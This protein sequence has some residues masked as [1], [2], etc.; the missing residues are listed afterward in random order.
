[1]GPL[2][3]TLDQRIEALDGAAVGAPHT[4]EYDDWHYEVSGDAFSCC[5]TTYEA[6]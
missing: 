4:K 5:C 6:G 1:M 3:T 2:A